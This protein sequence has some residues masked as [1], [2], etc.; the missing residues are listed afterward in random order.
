MPKWIIVATV[1]QAEASAVRTLAEFE[2]DEGDAL[3]KLEK[4]LNSY[5]RDVMAVKRREI[6]KMTDRS[7]LLRLSGRLSK[8]E[9]LVQLGQL[10]ADSKSAD[11]PNSLG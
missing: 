10:V 8:Y 4:V 6:F 5:D 7:Y 1:L 2:G 9:Y 11:L 3:S